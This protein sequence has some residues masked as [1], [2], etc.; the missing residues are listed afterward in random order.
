MK[1]IAYW[2][3]CIACGIALGAPIGFALGALIASFI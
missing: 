1:S 3:G 2:A